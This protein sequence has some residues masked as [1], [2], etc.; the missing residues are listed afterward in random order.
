MSKGT[1]VNNKS[2]S[3]EKTIFDPP[4]EVI[5]AANIKEYDELYK[6]SIEDREGF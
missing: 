4:K 2:D 1:E 3:N 6:R 5:E